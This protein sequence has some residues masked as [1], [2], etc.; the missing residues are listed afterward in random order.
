[1]K[2]I[3]A[4]LLACMM[5]TATFA[6]CGEE[7]ESH[8]DKDRSSKSSHIN[9]DEDEEDDK[10][11]D[12]K[13]SKKKKDKNTDDDEDEN[14]DDKSSVKNNDDDD[15]SSDKKNDI[16]DKEDDKSSDKKN[17]DDSS[18]KD[19][20][21]SSKTD[22]NTKSELSEDVCMDVLVNLFKSA[23][24]GDKNEVMKIL[25]PADLYSAFEKTGSL[26][27]MTEE[28]DIDDL[29]MEELEENMDKISIS[30]IEDCDED[31]ILKLETVYSSFYNL[32]SLM[33]DNN[34]SYN[35]L[36][37]GN[38]DQE[39]LMLFMEPAAAVS[40]L[41]NIDPSNVDLS[42]VYEDAKHVTY[43]FTDEDGDEDQEFILYKIKGE[44]WKIDAIGMVIL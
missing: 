40:D 5:I 18:K 23:D 34:I 27:I 30:N 15:K 42:I 37:S 38:I 25:L 39:T 11:D 41:D 26:D 20:E 1:M 44:D 7:K 16:E 10:E 24:K 28:F 9:D 32:F 8:R 3:I 31:E 13:S 12:D 29:D 14:E 35:D 2:K 33:A 19:K 6:S 17:D 43:T 21:N 4:L 22:R 36:M